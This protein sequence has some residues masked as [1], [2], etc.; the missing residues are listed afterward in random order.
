MALLPTRSELAAQLQALIEGRT[1]R[2]AV[3]GWAMRFVLDEGI[4]VSD[5]TVWRTLGKMGG[6][7]AYAGFDAYLYNEA[8]FR[9]W[10][11]QLLEGRRPEQNCIS[12]EQ[13]PAASSD[14]PLTPAQGG[15]KNG[16]MSPEFP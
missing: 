8:D 4:I 12:P 1:S 14:P 3:S 10:L 2:D 7:D 15:H 13:P 5:R 16:I 9:D 6:A 11:K